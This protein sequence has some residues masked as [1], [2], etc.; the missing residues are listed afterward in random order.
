MPR[1]KLPADSPKLRQLQALWLRA[2]EKPVE[3]PCGN[4]AS[5]ISVRFSL[6]HAI[7]A[8]REGGFG[9]DP[10]LTQAAGAVQITLMGKDQSIVR[11]S[12]SA[13]SEALDAALEKLGIVEPAP[14][15][16]MTSEEMAASVA[17]LAQATAEPDSGRVDYGQLMARREAGQ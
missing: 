12:K 6:Y 4:K 11:M 10:M 8:H 7:K 2:M 16:Q 1:A 13:A 15:Y 14:S 9:T 5:A 17:R 3:I